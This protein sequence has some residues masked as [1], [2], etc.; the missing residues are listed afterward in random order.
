[1]FLDLTAS[2]ELELMDIE[3][4]FS[5]GDLDEKIYMEQ[6]K[7]FEVKKKRELYL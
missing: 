5:H 7:G 1:M 3:T 4:S 2:L 6:P